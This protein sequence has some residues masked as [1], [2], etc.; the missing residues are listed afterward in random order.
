M[1]RH[2]RQPKVQGH[3]YLLHPATLKL[4]QTRGMRIRILAEWREGW[5][6]RSRAGSSVSMAGLGGLTLPFPQHHTEQA[7]DPAAAASA[8][9]H[10]RSHMGPLTQP[11][12]QAPLR[13]AA[14]S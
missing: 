10:A 14:D 11:P 3:Y 13:F 2:V 12:L 8:G 9:R 1:H 4:A 5:T 7:D 6:E